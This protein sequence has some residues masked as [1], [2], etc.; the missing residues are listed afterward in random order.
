LALVREG[1]TSLLDYTLPLASLLAGRRITRAIE[2]YA[3][4]WEIEDLWIPYFCVSTNLTTARTVVHR[5]GEVVRAVRASVSIPGVLPPVPDGADLL[6]DGGVLD[7]LPVEVARE[8]DPH[9]T[10]VA[11]DV[12]PPRGPSARDDYGQSVSGWQLLRD[13]LLPWRRA[14]ASTGDRRHH[15][16]VAG[17][18]GEPG[19]P[20]H[21]R[22]G[23]RRPLSQHPRQRRRS[24]RLRPGRSRRP[25]RLRRVDRAASRMGRGER[26]DLALAVPERRTRMRGTT[27]LLTLSWLACG[28]AG[29]AEPVVGL[30]CEGCEA[31][32]VGLPEGRSWE[33]RIAPVEEAGEPLVV[34]GVVRRADGTPV[35]GV[36]VYAYQTDARGF[37]PADP[38]QA[39][40]HARRHGRLRGWAETDVAGRYRF[41]TVRP[42]GYPNTDIPQH[43][44]LHVLELGRC[45]YFID[46]VTFD[47]DPR[48]TASQRRRLQGRGGSGS[49]SRRAVTTTPGGRGATS[50]SERA[51]RVTKPARLAS[52][53]ERRGHDSLVARVA[54]G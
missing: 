35:P 21:A 33:A 11:I 16:A 10:I 27:V 50:C 4:D 38:D 32:F 41:L 45:T 8:L 17:R 49:S 40:R 44:H 3:A 53:A 5:R 29:A 6:V 42:A 12:A 30:P 13:R 28:G 37:Y 36:V 51:S 31:V 26:I 25:R 47:D 18:D 39:D 24:A 54:L 9:G 52:R 1:F 43:I 48:L 46:D 34:D 14:A 22:T 2:R 7:N 23:A 20:A 19:A 15:P